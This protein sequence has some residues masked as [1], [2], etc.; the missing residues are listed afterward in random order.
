MTWGVAGHSNFNWNPRK[1]V[2]FPIFFEKEDLKQTP[3]REKRVL[4]KKIG[5]LLIA[6]EPAMI[7]IPVRATGFY[8][9]RSLKITA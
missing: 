4:S 1:I 6:R 3:K 5:F 2:V 9:Q 7:I 8:R